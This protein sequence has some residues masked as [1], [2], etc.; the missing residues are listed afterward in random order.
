MLMFIFIDVQYLQNVIFSFENGL[1]GQNQSSHT[2]EGVEGN[3]L[4]TP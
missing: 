3:F 4:P 2:M 1:N